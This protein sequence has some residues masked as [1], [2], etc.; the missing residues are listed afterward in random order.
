MSPWKSSWTASV[1]CK[2]GLYDW[3]EL[4]LLGQYWSQQQFG[5]VLHDS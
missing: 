2:I 5:I 3:D 4:P 1:K